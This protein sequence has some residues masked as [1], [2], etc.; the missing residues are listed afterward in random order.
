MN[1]K[2]MEKTAAFQPFLQAKCNIPSILKTNSERGMEL[3]FPTE[4]F[5]QARQEMARKI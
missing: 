1:E 4:L 5:V 2:Q 3:K